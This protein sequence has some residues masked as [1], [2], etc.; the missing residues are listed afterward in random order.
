MREVF[1]E[2]GANLAVVGPYGDK[3]RDALR[4]LLPA[5]DPVPA[6]AAVG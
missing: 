2:T 6:E 5:E 4:G 1:V 3:E